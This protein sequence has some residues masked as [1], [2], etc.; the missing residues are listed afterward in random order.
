[1]WFKKKNPLSNLSE[2]GRDAAR[3]IAGKQIVDKALNQR[4]LKNYKKSLSLSKQAYQEFRY[5]PAASIHGNTLVAAGRPDDAIRWLQDVFEDEL[6]GTASLSRIEIA[7]NLIWLVRDHLNDVAK[8]EKYLERARALVESEPSSKALRLVES[9]VDVEEAILLANKGNH[10]L[11]GELALKRLS[12]C[13]ECDRAK[14]VLSSIK[15]SDGNSFKVYGMILSADGTIALVRDSEGIEIRISRG[16]EEIYISA[17]IFAMLLLGARTQGWAADYLFSKND[18]GDEA[19]KAVSCPIKITEGD[20][21]SLAKLL[22][23]FREQE[24]AS[25]FVEFA[26]GGAFIAEES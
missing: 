14:L 16:M 8:A 5:L 11:A 18:I 2:E 20:A 17:V 25:E 9:G 19:I 26:L 21:L 4:N 24:S 15:E 7:T 1:M 12:L 10:E 22:E 13:P 3:Q 6:V 23:Q